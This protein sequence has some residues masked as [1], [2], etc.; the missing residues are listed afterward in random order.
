[1]DLSTRSTLVEELDGENVD[2]ATYQRCLAEL[3]FINRVSFTQRSTLRWLARAARTLPVGSTFSVLDVGYGHGALLRA[4]ARWARRRGLKAQLSGI[5]LNPRAAIAARSVTP[6]D[7]TID[8]RTGDVLSYTPGEPLDFVVSSHFTHHLS[9][10]EVVMFLTW[11]EANSRHGWHI[12]DLHRSAVSYYCFQL[13]GHLMGW[14][15]IVR[16]D[17]A[18]SIARSFR[19]QGWQAFLNQAGLQAEISWHMPFRFCVSREKLARRSQLRSLL[20]GQLE[21]SGSGAS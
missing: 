6:S 7:M 5:D 2:I 4:I 20:H 8:Y 11:L 9:D 21:P 16:S 13:V 10:N 17:G 18:I 15:R 19:R 14:H 12:A 3:D 1:M